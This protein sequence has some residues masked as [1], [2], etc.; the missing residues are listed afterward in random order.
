MDA[1]DLPLRQDLAVRLVD[2]DAMRRE[3]IWPENSKFVEIL[4]GRGAI[5]LAAIV[6]F[7]LSLS[8]VNEDRSVVLPCERGRILQCF[9]GIGVDRMG[10]N[11]GVDQRVAL[12][13]LQKFLRIFEHCVVGLVV[14]GGKIEDGLAQ[15]SAHSGGFRFFSDGV[16]KVIHV[17]ESG[18]A[19]A[20]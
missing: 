12:P 20:D 14:W 17:R 8:H 5:F 13:A 2:P 19:A 4:H 18:D 7:F 3:H 16:L 1:A 15:R 9:L 6:Q 10:R 11:G